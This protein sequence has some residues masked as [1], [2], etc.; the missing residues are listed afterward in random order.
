MILRNFCVFEG[1]DGSGTSTQISELKKAFS[2][3]YNKMTG[4][5]DQIP[6]VFTCEPTSGPVGVLIR[7]ALR[8]EVTVH[9]DTLARLF[10]ADRCEHLWG[11][12][13]IV[14]ALDAGRAVISDRYLFS[15]LAYQGE[16]ADRDLAW[17]LNKN[18]PLPEYLFYFDIDPEAAMDRVVS[19]GQALE[20][21]EKRNFQHQVHH[22]YREILDKFQQT[23]PGMTIIYID[24][25][26][27]IQTI[28]EKIWS[29]L[30]P[31]PIL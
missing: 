12:E 19:R 10:A 11:R 1:I 14:A 9:P 22:R 29:I 6:V 13:G 4:T 7:E 28:A 16:A 26:Q 17:E 25:R 24:S 23:E 3:H 21:F 2:L 27:S 31:L 30:A 8:G 18:Y 20:I 5:D 15:S